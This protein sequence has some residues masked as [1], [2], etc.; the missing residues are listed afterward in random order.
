MHAWAGVSVYVECCCASECVWTVCCEH[1]I[2][3][4][5]FYFRV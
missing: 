3:N 2:K 1:D 5:Q 4:L